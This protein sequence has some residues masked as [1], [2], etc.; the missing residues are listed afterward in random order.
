MPTNL[1]SIAARMAELYCDLDGCSSA[2]VEE[3]AKYSGK[4]PAQ[5]Q[6][7]ITAAITSIACSAQRVAD[8]QLGTLSQAEITLADSNVLDIPIPEA[9][10]G[11][12]ATTANTG[13]VFAVDEDPETVS[14]DETNPSIGNTFSDIEREVRVFAADSEQL[15]IKGTAGD[16]ILIEFWG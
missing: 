15:R 3:A 12:R 2:I 14:T 11:F 4:P 1:D 7:I 13:V 9:A 5:L 8:A 6:A 10:K 16:V